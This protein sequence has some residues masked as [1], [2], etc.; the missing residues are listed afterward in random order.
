MTKAEY[1][2]LVP[3]P[4]PNEINSGLS[5]LSQSNVIATIGIPAERKSVDC[6]KV[7]NPRLK[8]KIVTEDVGPF[9]VT[10]HRVAVAALRKIFDD[11]LNDHPELYKLLGSAGMLCVRVVRGGRNWSNHAWGF[12]IDLTIGGILDKRGDDKVQQGI[13]ILYRYFHRHRWYSGMEFSTEDAMHF[14]PSN[15]LFNEWKSA[16]L[17]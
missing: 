11:V 3:C 15:E 2:K 7:T 12:A 14:E 4:K 5:A 8:I 9:R 1:Q 16:G 13:L 10:G 6:G 17:I